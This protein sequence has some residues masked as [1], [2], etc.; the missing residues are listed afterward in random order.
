MAPRHLI[1]AT[2]LILAASAAYAANLTCPTST[3]L[4]QLAG[5]IRTQMPGSGSNGYVP[6]TA[7]EQA[8]L[9]TVARQMLQGT[10]STTLPASLTG[11]ME[12]RAFTD[13]GNGKTYC[14][15]MEV[16]DANNN[17]VVDRGWGTFVTDAAAQR[18]L[19]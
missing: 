9:R 10:C 13:S 3:T 4:E 7:A 16:L 19:S 18:E 2:L 12:R 1:L 17:G 15:L 14:L 11:I 8:D 5:C 6:P